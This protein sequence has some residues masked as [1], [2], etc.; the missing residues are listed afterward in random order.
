MAA[1]FSLQQD[2]VP[3]L[4]VALETLIGTMTRDDAVT[5]PDLAAVISV[6]IQIYAY[7]TVNSAVLCMP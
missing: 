5:R 7:C 4:S 6:S 1:D 3:A 2:E